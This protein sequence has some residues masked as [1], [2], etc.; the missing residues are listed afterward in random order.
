M[1]DTTEP[2]V[3]KPRSGWLNIAVD[4]GPVLVFFLVYKYFSPGDAEAN[5]LAEVLAV[6]KG[7]GAFVAA[8]IVALIVSK[9]KLGRVSPMLWLST[10]LIVI[11]GGI[12]IWTGDQRVIQAKP[13]VIYV[14]FGLVLLAGWLR[15]KALLRILLEAAFE[16]LSDEGWLKLSR[17][18]GLFFLVLAAL[19]EGLVLYLDFG[20]WLAAKLWVFLPLTFLFTFLHIPMLMRHGMGREEAEDE[21]VAHTPPT[22]E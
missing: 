9:W 6:I 16:G 5:P 18:W 4:Y 8:A 19:N 17:N 2:E 11:F 1:A 10:G 12:T 15:G 7:T 14:L 20:A 21:A 22:G 3:E 13:T